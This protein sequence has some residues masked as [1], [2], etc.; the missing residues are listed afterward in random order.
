MSQRDGIWRPTRKSDQNP[1]KMPRSSQNILAS[2][3]D[4]L[5][6]DEPQNSREAVQKSVVGLEQIKA[7][8]IRDI[9]N[10]LNTKSQILQVPDAYREVQ[11]SVFT[12][13]MPDYTTL[14]PKGTSTRLELRRDI[15]KALAMFEPRLRD[16][17]VMIQPPTQ[18]ERNLRLKIT[19]TLVVD[20]INEPVAFDTLFDVNKG[21]YK[22]PR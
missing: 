4:R 15:E 11:D 3:L 21:E 1:A 16:V 7:A 20:P 19:A 17:L 10:L 22:I 8:V 6:D 9:E 12:Y 18:E 2:I 13:G 5:M 14:N